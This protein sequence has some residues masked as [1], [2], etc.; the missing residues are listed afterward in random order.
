M[1]SDPLTEGPIVRTWGQLLCKIM[2]PGEDFSG[3]EGQC[4]PGHSLCLVNEKFLHQK[5]DRKVLGRCGAISAL[6]S[7]ITKVLVCVELH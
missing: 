5:V 7:V 1:L 4:L 6:T 2:H 3:K